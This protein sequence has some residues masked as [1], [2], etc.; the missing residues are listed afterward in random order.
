MVARNDDGSDTKRMKL[1]KRC[2]IEFLALCRRVDTIK[3]VSTDNHGIDGMLSYGTK[4]VVQKALMVCVPLLVHQL[5]TEVPVGGMEDAV[6]PGAF[7]GQLWFKCVH[8]YLISNAGE[9]L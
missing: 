6:D 8:L 3:D 9:R 2:V 5:F 1:S 7:G 4:E